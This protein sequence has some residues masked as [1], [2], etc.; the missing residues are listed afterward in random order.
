MNNLGYY[1]KLDRNTVHVFYFLNVNCNLPCHECTDQGKV[2]D[3][4]KLVKEGKMSRLFIYLFI[5]FK[6]FKNCKKS[7]CCTIFQ[8]CVCIT[9]NWQNFLFKFQ[10]EGWLFWVNV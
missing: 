1:I 7:L 8:K 9:S 4:D 2:G 10:A 3:L 5:I 6:V